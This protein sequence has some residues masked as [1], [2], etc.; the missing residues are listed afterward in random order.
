M[1]AVLDEC[2]DHEEQVDRRSGD[3]DGCDANMA[4]LYF[5][6]FRAVFCVDLVCI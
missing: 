2:A 4:G 3:D 6:C 5:N 1:P